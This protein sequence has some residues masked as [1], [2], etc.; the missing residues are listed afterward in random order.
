MSDNRPPFTELSVI[1]TPG[2]VSSRW[3]DDCLVSHLF[4]DVYMLVE[5]GPEVRR[6][7]S[8]GDHISEESE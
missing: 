2:A 4:M 3:C 6:V 7:A 1:L 8:W 5:R